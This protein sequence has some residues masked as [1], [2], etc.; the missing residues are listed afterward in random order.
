[1]AFS[2]S[3]LRASSGWKVSGEVALSD[4]AL[5]SRRIAPVPVFDVNFEASGEGHFYPAERRLEIDAATLRV[6]RAEARISGTMEHGPEHY[7]LALR[8]AMPLTPCGAALAAIPED[9]LGQLRGFEWDGELGGQASL[10]VDSR[11]LDATQ[12]RVTLANTCQFVSVPALADLRRFRS[13][14]R[15]EVREPDGELFSMTTGPGSAQW[16][17]IHAISPYVIHAILAH[18]D[19]GFF[20][21]GGFSVPSVERAI[22]RNLREGR[23]VLGA[24]TIS[25]QLA[26]NLFLHREKTMARK[27]QEVL[28]TWWLE[29]ALSKK[30]LL[31]LYLNV[32]EYGPAIYG[33][34]HAARHYFGR[35][36]DELSPAEGAFLA[37]HPA[38][39]EAAP[40]SLQPGSPRAGDA[41]ADGA[42]PSPYARA[43][44]YRR[45]RARVRARRVARVSL[46]PRGRAPRASSDPGRAGAPAFL[47]RRYDALGGVGDLGI[48]R[49][50]GRG[51]FERRLS[52]VSDQSVPRSFSSTL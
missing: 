39:P 33:I 37:L 51:A 45:R 25:M 47:D 43:A 18:E 52:R 19:A 1:M 9:L 6:G 44:P 31:E 20:R 15:H 23:F 30:K 21:H 11:D 48:G 35:D 40:P 2:R 42:L 29:S 28:L 49:G 50:R 38:G 13:P 5:H 8:A 16:S 41:R 32:I 27:V 34:R 3:R 14:F 7:A 24:S 46:S 22:V 26:K 36:P 17:S 10:R 12:L 4:G